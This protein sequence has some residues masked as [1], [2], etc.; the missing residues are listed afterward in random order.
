MKRPLCE[1]VSLY[2]LNK[3]CYRISFVLDFSFQKAGWVAVFKDR[4]CLE[5]ALTHWL[6]NIEMTADLTLGMFVWQGVYMRASCLSVDVVCT[7][8]VGRV[9]NRHK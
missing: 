1:E 4:L 6:P 3:T 8:G 9:V 5:S 2:S 7:P